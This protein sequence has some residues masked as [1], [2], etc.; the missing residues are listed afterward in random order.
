MKNFALII[1]LF[2]I[3]F[4]LPIFF[5]NFEEIECVEGS[6][7]S[8]SSGESSSLKQFVGKKFFYIYSNGKKISS[9][10]GILKY[11]LV[12][13]PFSKKA[14]FNLKKSLPFIAVNHSSNSFFLIDEDGVVVQ[15]TDKKVSLPVVGVESFSYKVADKIPEDLFLS[16][17][18]FSYIHNLYKIEKGTIFGDR[19]EIYIRNGP[20]LVLPKEDYRR[21]LG[22]ARFLLDSVTAN[23]EKFKLDKSITYITID[24]RYKNPVLR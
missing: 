15:Y 6:N 10:P 16:L 8:C 12:F 22:R 13:F 19:I 3:F 4:L 7:L 18:V 17:R 24:L 5:V 2:V 11:D 9:L 1:S 23:P 14:I 21:I 20:I